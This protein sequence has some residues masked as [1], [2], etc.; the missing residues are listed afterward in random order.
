MRKISGRK[1]RRT[2]MAA[3]YSIEFNNFRTRVCQRTNG[4]VAAEYFTAVVRLEA[5]AHRLAAI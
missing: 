3:G 4:M 1:N 5:T 2:K